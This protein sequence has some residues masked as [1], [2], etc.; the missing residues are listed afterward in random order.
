[1]KAINT[2]G[3][4]PNVQK[5]W[6]TFVE[7]KCSEAANAALKVY[8][9]LMSKVAGQLPCDNEKIQKSHKHALEQGIAQLEAETMGISS[10]T[11]GKYRR[12]M[13]VRSDKQHKN[14]LHRIM[15]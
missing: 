15:S 10:V 4:I 7:T 1:V 14:I 11:T 9:A 6:E 3:V 13:T 5:A 2:P 12:E 8:E